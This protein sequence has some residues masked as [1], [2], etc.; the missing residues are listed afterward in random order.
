MLVAPVW[1]PRLSICV[2]RRP[3][4]SFVPLLRQPLLQTRHHFSLSVST[5]STPTFPSPPTTRLG[6]CDK[7]RLIFG[8]T[9]VDAVAAHL[10]SRTPASLFSPPLAS[11]SLADTTSP[12]PRGVN[13]QHFPPPSPD[14][15]LSL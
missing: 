11:A 4:H 15:I 6:R 9:S 8:G 5:F 2:Q 14:H 10:R 7:E 1:M 3:H 12:L 13:A